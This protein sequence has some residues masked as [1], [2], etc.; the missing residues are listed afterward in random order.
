MDTQEIDLISPK[1]IEEA[2]SYEQFVTLVEKLFEVEKTTNGDNSESMLNYTKI[3]LQRLNRISRTSVLEDDLVKEITAN[4]RRMIWLVLN[5]GW[6]GDS[7][8]NL[9][10]INMI[11]ESSDLIDLKIILR[12]QNPQLMD[13]FLTNGTRSIPKLIAL[14]T[15]TLEVMGTWGPRPV[16][17]QELFYELRENP[18]LSG[19]ERSRLLHT[20]YAKN[21]GKVLQQEFTHLIKEWNS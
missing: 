13:Q 1:I 15:D 20:W 7:G 21:K 8:Q 10:Y 4:R 18:E 9:P 3:T 6:C 12:D 11:A 14:D 2:Y 5:E 17:A 16:E 19:K